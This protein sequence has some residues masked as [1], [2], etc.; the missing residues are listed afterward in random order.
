MFFSP[1]KLPPALIDN[2]F[3]H[4]PP[5]APKWWYQAQ[6][7]SH[8]FEIIWGPQ[9]LSLVGWVD[10]VFLVDGVRKIESIPIFKL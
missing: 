10:I 1:I 2:T 4:L 9:L 8:I 5:P 3:P 6:T 7:T